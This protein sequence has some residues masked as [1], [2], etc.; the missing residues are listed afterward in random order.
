MVCQSV[1][2]QMVV[3][4]SGLVLKDVVQS[5]LGSDGCGSDVVEFGCSGGGE[6]TSGLGSGC[7]GFEKHRGSEASDGGHVG[8]IWSIVG[9]LIAVLRMR[10]V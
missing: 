4:H 2:V 3:I 8:W 7:D 10:F 6:M 5:G 9:E 1:L